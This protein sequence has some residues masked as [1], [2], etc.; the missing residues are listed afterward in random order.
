[1]EGEEKVTLKEKTLL[2]TFLMHCFNSLVCDSPINYWCGLGSVSNKEI[3]SD[4][5]KI[6]E[7]FSFIDNTV[8]SH[9]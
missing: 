4:L 9:L 1:M 2:L 7:V 6:C 8:T 5:K 3:E